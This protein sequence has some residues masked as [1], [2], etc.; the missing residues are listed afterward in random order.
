MNRYL[1]ICNK[2]ITLLSFI[3]AINGH[4]YA[5]CPPNMD[6][7]NGTFAGWQCWVGTVDVVDTVNQITLRTVP[8]PI[9]GQHTMLSSFPGDGLD[10][11]GGFPKNCPNGSGHSIKLGN[12]RAG[13]AAEGISYDFVI[14]PT[15]NKFSI[16]YNFA[17]VFEDPDHEKIQQPRL[18]V[19][20]IDLD[21]GTWIDC[22]TF[23]YIAYGTLPGFSVSP[24]QPHNT[25][26]RYKPWTENTIYLNGYQGKTIRLFIKTADCTYALHFG[27]AYVDVSSKCENSLVGETFCAQDTA[28]TINA[29]SGYQNYK[30]YNANYTQVLGSQQSLNF[31]PPPVPGTIV[32]VELL[33][34]PGQGCRD[35]LV[36]DLRDTLTVKANAGA[37]LISCNG[38]PV[39]LGTFPAGGVRYQWT[40]SQGLSN[41]NIANPFAL[42]DVQTNYMLTATSL[43]GGCVSRD[44]VSVSLK[45]VD[46]F[47]ELIGDAVHCIG[48]GPDPVLKVM[49]ADSIQWYKD[50]VLIPGA[51]QATYAV[52]STGTYYAL[53]LSDICTNPL[54]TKNVSLIVDTPVV[55]ITYPLL[56]IPFNLPVQLKARG[57]D[58]ATSVLWKPAVS[59]DKPNTFE[60]YFKGVQPQ[61]Y[62]VELTSA[63]GCVTVDTQVVKTYKKI[64]IYVPSV[65]TPDG[66]GRN[67]YLKPLLLGFE[68]LKYFRVFNRG[69]KLLFETQSELPGWNGR[70]ANQLQ[71]PQAIVWMLEAID[72]DGKSHFRK[73]S[74]LL[75]H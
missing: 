43:G 30:W 72:V 24:L 27:Y 42:P 12:D 20:V 5:Q 66:D 38:T 9:E 10:E 4:A 22:F 68:K 65:F 60:P 41:P 35:T 31:Q 19:E 15:S 74:S 39:Q 50:A 21:D 57:R 2:F 26:V 52:R 33:P 63:K 13:G 54:Q 71:E 53:L 75:M 73:G 45:N 44:N 32:A 25:P 49:P 29:P 55:G 14:P 36:V 16:T 56:D 58:F 17:L 34:Y 37:D 62:L 23:S 47:V 46:S 8:A 61:T 11:Y 3:I 6:F 18:N 40:P 48:D 51:N 1:K 7:E 64:E 28:L 69:G 70:I 67:D 59:L